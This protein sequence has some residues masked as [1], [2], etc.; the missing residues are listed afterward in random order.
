MKRTQKRIVAELRKPGAYLTGAMYSRLWVV[1]V[2]GRKEHDCLYVQNRVVED[3]RSAGIVKMKMF[4]G[5]QYLALA[6]GGGGRG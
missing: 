1:R 3:M 2:P 4:A 6:A 5:G